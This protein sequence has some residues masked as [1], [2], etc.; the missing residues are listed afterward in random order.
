MHT[1]KPRLGRADDALLRKRH[2]RDNAKQ[3]AKK[4]RSGVFAKFIIDNFGGIEYLSSGS[5]IL[6]VAGGNGSLAFELSFVHGIPCT[7]VDPRPIKF[8]K[9]KTKDILL[10]ARGEYTCGALND[11]EYDISATEWFDDIVVNA[12]AAH[13]GERDASLCVDTM[14]K[15][16]REAGAKYLAK[17]GLTQHLCLF[18]ASYV[19]DRPTFNTCSCVVGMHPDEATEPIVDFASAAGKRWAV[20][21]CCVFPSAHPD[22]RTPDGKPVVLTAD[23]VQYLGAKKVPG[24]EAKTGTLGGM[25]GANMVVWSELFI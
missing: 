24:G 16:M 13:A 22:R 20:V 10:K 7:V 23:F 12:W 25:P 14:A 2:R 5:G 18:D 4:A 21:P 11:V 8:S 15:V 17:I 9:K 3:K 1:S 6:D 19:Q